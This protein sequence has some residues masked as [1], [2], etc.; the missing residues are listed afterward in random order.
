[1]LM[2]PHKR[3]TSR[4]VAMVQR[5]VATIGCYG[6]SHLFHA[7]L[8]CVPFTLGIVLINSRV[9]GIHTW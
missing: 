5:L 6:T 3:L 7:H 9:Y 8:V 1:M 4:L 2:G